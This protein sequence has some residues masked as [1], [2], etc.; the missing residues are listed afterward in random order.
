M[1][2]KFMWY[3]E[4]IYLKWQESRVWVREC[5]VQGEGE[6]MQTIPYDHTP[7][8]KT[9]STPNIPLASFLANSGGR[10]RGSISIGDT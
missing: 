7:P 1:F 3:T 2:I 10:P 6:T 9:R 8:C 5:M 4:I